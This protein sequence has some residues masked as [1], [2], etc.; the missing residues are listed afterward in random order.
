M[1]VFHG[2]DV[3]EDDG[4][5]VIEVRLEL[6]YVCE[7]HAAIIIL[8]RWTA[9]HYMYIS[10]DIH[11]HLNKHRLHFT[12]SILWTTLMITIKKA[13]I[14]SSEARLICLMMH[15]FTVAVSYA[16]FNNKKNKGMQPNLCQL[17]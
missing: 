15:Y 5:V 14:S 16:I 6:A 7:V 11:T 10:H 8:S 9:I 2:L 12:S 4:P 3:L 13:L 1:A 17:E